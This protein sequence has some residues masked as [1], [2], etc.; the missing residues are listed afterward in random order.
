M[1]TVIV[2]NNG[3]KYVFED[4]RN[5]QARA[6]SDLN[7]TTLVKAVNKLGLDGKEITGVTTSVEGNIK[8]VGCYV[9]IYLS[10]REEDIT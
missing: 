10:V 8:L 1:E 6:V 9:K 3:V 4:V 2:D 7:I 5:E